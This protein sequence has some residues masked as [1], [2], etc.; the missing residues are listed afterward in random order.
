MA[1]QEHGCCDQ[2][3]HTAF[4]KRKQ[5]R[6]GFVRPRS[7]RHGVSSTSVVVVAIG[8]IVGAPQ[9]SS[10]CGHHHEPQSDE[11]WRLGDK[12][13]HFCMYLGVLVVSVDLVLLF[14][15]VLRGAPKI[16]EYDS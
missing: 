10:T 4:E 16:K 5:D 2:E 6:P 11:E 7:S 1:A 8:R 13:C 12:E 3:G 9:S 14:T 15:R